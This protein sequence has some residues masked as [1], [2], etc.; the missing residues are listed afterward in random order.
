MSRDRREQ[1]L[2][3]LPPKAAGYPGTADLPV[4]EI[5]GDLAAALEREKRALVQAPP[6]AG[7][8]TIIPLALLGQPWLKAKKI[9]VLEPR[10]LAARACAGRMAALLGERPGQTVGYQVRLD[11][12]IGPE[13]R[14]EVITEGILTRRIQNDPELSGAGLLIFD[15]FH[16]RHLHSDLGLALALESAE[17]FSPDLRLLVMSATMDMAAL[18]G[19]MGE[20]PVIESRG[21]SWPV[22]T[23]YLPPDAAR[24]GS[25]QAVYRSRNKGFE[26]L[27]ACRAAIV[28]A[29]TESRGDILVFLPGAAQIRALAG[30]LASLVAD[31]P[32][33]SLFPLFGMLSPRDQ[34]AAIA[35]SPPGSRK[36]V[37]ATSI[38]ETSLTIEGV[39]VVV[40]TGL[41]RVPRF[42]PRTGMSRLETL[43][44]SRASADQRR[45]R[46][47]RTGPGIC[48]RLWSEH[49]HQ[50]LI[51][52][53]RPE[54]LQADLAPLVLEL[55]L[56]GVGDP[57]DLSWLDLP[58]D[59][60]L[61]AAR[62]LLTQLGALDSGGRI[63][64]H[65]R[66]LCAAGIHPRLAQMV[67][68]GK[69]TGQGFTA[70]C[71]AALT[72]GRDLLHTGDRYDPDIRLRLELL[73]KCIRKKTGSVSGVGNS[74]ARQ[75]LEQA[76][77]LANRFGIRTVPVS[78]EAAGRLLALAWP[79]RIAKLRGKGGRTYVMAS[80]TG[81]V[82]YE[83]NALSGR[84][85]VVAVDAGGTFK[86]AVIQLAAPYDKEDLEADFSDRI[87]VLEEVAW[88]SRT[89]S[90]RCVASRRYGR[91]VLDQFPKPLPG[92]EAVVPALVRG[93]RQEGL[94]LLPWS[95]PSGSLCSRVTF[96]RSLGYPEF[97]ALPDLSRKT[98]EKTLDL[99]L[100]PFLGGIA[101]EAGLKKLDLTAALKSLFSWDQLI[102]VERQ[103]PTHLKVPSGSR[104][105]L[106]YEDENGPLEAPVLAVRLQEMFGL[107]DTPTV[108]AGRV[109]VTLHLLSPAH[110]PVQITRDLANFWRTT[111][112]EVKKDLMG[113]YPKH[114]WPEDP[115]ATPPTRRAKPR[116]K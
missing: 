81:C 44:V 62:E 21:R 111:Y 7:K 41:A 73:E 103:A 115:L 32:S 99:W 13:S 27:P 56:W 50:G 20:V 46:A 110:R 112:A 97:S 98:L 100:S 83:E 89:R 64:D 74:R 4:L 43:T 94:D 58:P 49:V 5:L 31:D 19:L 105:P 86:D 68:R 10:R 90:V 24:T 109:K 47:G 57:R 80:G 26:I 39:R 93:I 101:S 96:L 107:T 91:I 87:E 40:D 55:A 106:A 113:R 82:F 92:P 114:Y 37:L 16:E 60:G 11:R 85:F 61:A 23:V 8:T 70:C 38:A 22:E 76:R 9:L 104:I 66:C 65:G 15:E 54:I 77:Q 29:L 67:L 12:C 72:E 3:L 71:L 102:L 78:P 95:K 51:P 59:A 18:S 25:R 88:D 2:A 35:P 6:G 17:V 84:E 52:F 63:T 108:A 53:N 69:A 36:I 28:R 79:E 75:V 45:G 48:Y 1:G 42:S 33:L 116:K 14:I 34:A 30:D